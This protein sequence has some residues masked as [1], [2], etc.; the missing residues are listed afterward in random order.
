MSIEAPQLPD[1]SVGEVRLASVSFAGRLDAGVTLTG[2]PTVTDA[3]GD[4]TI[5]SASVST[6]NLT[7]N[8]ETVVTGDAVQFLVTGGTAGTTYPIRISC[9]TTSSPAETVRGRVR[10]RV[11][12]D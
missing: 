8:G 11:V 7:I 10:L 4:L 5:S 6:G 1:K 3:T 2:T 9:A 12:A